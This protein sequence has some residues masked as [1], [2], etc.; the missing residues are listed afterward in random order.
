MRGK[1]EK[2]EGE[3]KECE[4]KKG[5]GKV[6]FWCRTS[7]KTTQPWESVRKRGE[8]NLLHILSMLNISIQQKNKILF[9]TENKL[10]ELILDDKKFVFRKCLFVKKN[11]IYVL[12]KRYFTS[13]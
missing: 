2:D 6:V 5:F 4:S 11:L 3:R 12:A 1:K 7:T 9:A 10:K 8:K 13:N